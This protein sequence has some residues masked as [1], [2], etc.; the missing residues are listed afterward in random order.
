VSGY[1]WR[2][3]PGLKKSLCAYNKRPPGV[4]RASK[5]N[6]QI[7]LAYPL[8]PISHRCCM[9]ALSDRVWWRLGSRVLRMLP[10]CEVVESE[11]AAQRKHVA[12]RT[13]FANGQFMCLSSRCGGACGGVDL[14]QCV[15][16]AQQT[17]RYLE[18]AKAP[19]HSAYRGHPS[20]DHKC[21]QTAGEALEQMPKASGC[22][23]R[24]TYCSAVACE[25]VRD[26]RNSPPKA[27][28]EASNARILNAVMAL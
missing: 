26:A 24:T 23:E 12:Q 14:L 27:V 9:C 28:G 15:K 20:E 25:D 18:Q 13:A 16:E 2:A 8:L 10:C 6:V 7:L 5:K 17:G 4:P 11:R 3:H 1:G 21:I 22:L 19:M